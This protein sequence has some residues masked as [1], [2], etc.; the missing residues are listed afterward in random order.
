[1][2][3]YVDI[4][5]SN[6]DM[7]CENGKIKL[8]KKADEILQRV[9][10]RLRRIKG[11]WFLNVNAGIP[12]YEGQILGGKDFNYVKLVISAEINNTLGVSDIQELN[13]ITDPKTKKTSI[14]A[15]IVIDESVYELTEE[16]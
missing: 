4:A 2:R 8:V 6:D 14:Y 15:A 16:V 3:G 7:I 13:L 12:Y 5:M 1:M 11:E 9:R 10:T